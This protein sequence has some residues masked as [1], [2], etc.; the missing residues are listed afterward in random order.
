MNLGLGA[1]HRDEVVAGQLKMKLCKLAAG[2][3]PPG[4]SAEAKA[5]GLK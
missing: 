3:T 4:L 2:G 1:A 5:W